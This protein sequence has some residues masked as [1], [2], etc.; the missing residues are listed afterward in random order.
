MN[1]TMKIKDYKFIDKVKEEYKEIILRI[2]PNIDESVLNKFIIKKIEERI[3]IQKAM[4]HNNYVKQ[5]LS[6]DLL[7]ITEWFYKNKPITAG[8]GVFFQNQHKVINPVAQM[9]RNFMKLRKTYKDKLKELTEGTF[10]YLTND[11]LQLSEKT[12][13]NSYYGVN[14]APSSN[15]FN[16]YTASSVTGSGQSL[17]STTELAFEAFMANNVIFHNLDE[18]LIFINNVLKTKRN[19]KADFLP[20]ISIEK[21]FNKLKDTFNEFKDSYSDIIFDLLINLNQE[22]LNRIYYKNNLYEFCSIPLILN[23]LSKV[24]S[25]VEQ[26]KNPNKIPEPIKEDLKD[27][28]SYL[29][30][31]VFHN[32]FAYN[33]IN[34]LKKDPRR[35]VTVIDTDSNMV[36]IHPWVLFTYG[37]II[38]KHDELLKRDPMQ[39]KFISINI[40][41]YVL[42]N[43]IT[44]VLQKYTKIAHIPEDFRSTINMKNEFLFSRLVL[45]T[46]KKRYLSTVRLREGEEFNPEKLDVKGHDFNKST[47]R[48]ETK[49][50]FMKIVKER[51]LQVDKISIPDILRDLEKFENIILDSLKR[52]EKNF[53]IPASVKELEAYKDPLSQQGVRGVILWNYVYPDGAIQLPE[54]VDTIKLT[55]QTEEQLEKLYNINKDYYEIIKKNIFENMN[56][57]ISKKGASVIAIPRNIETIPEWIIPFIDYNTIVHDNLSRFYS[58]LESFGLETIK[59]SK[60]LCF[61]NILNV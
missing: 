58:V 14:G 19:I 10:D 45:S 4:L 27:I 55:L 17:I 25:K 40:M 21:V 37:N 43:M 59:A 57:K 30:E 32:Y 44:E 31:F 56:E 48:E 53:L 8:F 33:R 3:K 15:F 20:D 16:I 6:V 51:I 35:T 13:S 24:Y 29:K 5:E 42:T 52:G 54:K 46:T 1:A 41:C 38:S 36:N 28:W 49:T 60:K 47:T 18:C 22:E 23:K 11:R 34:R 7:G 26:F 12:N 61:S 2:Y 50:Y 9:L 39:L